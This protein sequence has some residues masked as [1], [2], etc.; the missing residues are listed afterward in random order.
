MTSFQ[1]HIVCVGCVT[2][3]V[4]HGEVWAD[5]KEKGREKGK[6]REN[7]RAHGRLE[8]GC[9]A[10]CNFVVYIQALVFRIQGER[11]KAVK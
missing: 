1:I 6:E 7:D 4:R 11:W 3:V 10:R 2:R 5:E 9:K 8:L